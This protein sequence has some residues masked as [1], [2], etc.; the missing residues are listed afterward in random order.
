MF[1]RIALRNWIWVALLLGLVLAQ[2]QEAGPPPIEGVY[3]GFV[4]NQAVVA[5]FKTDDGLWGRYYFRQEGLDIRLEGQYKKQIYTLS[6]VYP[7]NRGGAFTLARRRDFIGQVQLV[8]SYSRGKTRSEVVLR[9]LKRQDLVAGIKSAWLQEIKYFD[10]YLFLKFDRP[11][12]AGRRIRYG[13]MAFRWYTEP[14]SGVQMVRLEGNYAV[15]AA[16]ETEQF[17]RATKALECNSGKRQG[18]SSDTQVAWLTRYT[19]SLRSYVRLCGGAVPSANSLTFDVRSGQKLALEDLYR[20]LR[21]PSGYDPGLGEDTN[22]G[23]FPDYLLARRRVLVTKALLASPKTKLNPLCWGEESG[24]EPT[25]IL[26]ESWYLTGQGLMLQMDFPQ[27]LDACDTEMLIPYGW[28]R[29][30]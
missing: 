6:E 23:L 22:W 5:Q 26:R 10:P 16:L 21:V 14:K 15:N 1:Q 12:S 11:L 8:G 28:L 30:R 7:A 27:G 3:L 19:L 25:D 9:P 13:R 18:Y 20:I 17:K 2:G 29:R 24:L 4:G